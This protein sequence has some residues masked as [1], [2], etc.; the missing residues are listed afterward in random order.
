M[1]ITKQSNE[2]YG[3]CLI[4]DLKTFLKLINLNLCPQKRKKTLTASFGVVKNAGENATY[5]VLQVSF[6]TLPTVTVGPKTVSFAIGAS[7]TKSLSF[8]AIKSPII[9]GTNATVIV[10]LLLK[11]RRN[12]INFILIRLMIIPAFNNFNKKCFRQFSLKLL[13][14]RRQAW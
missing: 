12:Q 6:M 4:K 3:G 9:N 11:Q 14:M 10:I 2:Y 8:N 13:K 7:A 1:S 5:V